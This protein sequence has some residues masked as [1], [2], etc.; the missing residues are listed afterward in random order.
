MTRLTKGLSREQRERIAKAKSYARTS[1]IISKIE[2]TVHVGDLDFLFFKAG[3]YSLKCNGK[4]VYIGET[5]SLMTRISQHISENTK[6]FNSISFEIFEGSDKER[7]HKER[8]MIKRLKPFYNKTHKESKRSLRDVS[9][10][11]LY[12]A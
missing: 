11:S 3:I 7:K 1:R 9:R 12:S 10:K 4:V 6:I 8:S 2:N 5:I